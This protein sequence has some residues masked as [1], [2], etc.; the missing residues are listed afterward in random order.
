LQI[1]Q[2]VHQPPLLGRCRL[3]LLALLALLA[4]LAAGTAT[5][6]SPPGAVNLAANLQFNHNY[7]RCVS[8]SLKVTADAVA[9]AVGAPPHAL[10]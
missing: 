9:R 7:A 4:N 1:L 8:M 6:T 10:K 3:E 2:P 5:R